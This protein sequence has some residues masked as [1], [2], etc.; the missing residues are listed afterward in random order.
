MATTTNQGQQQYTEPAHNGVTNVDWAV[1]VLQ[2]LGAPVTNNNVTTMLQWMQ[3]ENGASTWT[4]TAGANNPLNNGYGSGGG[5]GL[6]SY[7]DLATAAQDV[8][9]NLATGAHG[10]NKV[11]SDLDASAD[12][13]TTAADII[14]S[15]WAESH[16]KNGA[17]WASGV[18]AATVKLV[19]AATSAAN[20][21]TGPVATG[22][23]GG[24]GSVIQNVA[25][26]GAAAEGAASTAATDAELPFKFLGDVIGGFGIGWKA[27]LT[28]I[29][30]ILLIGV[31][32]IIAFRHQAGEAASIA[33]IG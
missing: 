14:S 9:A 12:P 17:D 19:N 22:S 1:W 30:G 13:S 16:Y 11:V 26:A 15:G 29:G 24:L 28:I 8:A 2:D 32:I 10:Y 20:G 4:G 18:S 3:S 33:A 25:G 27:V 23:N 6:G 7:P 31:G 5:S 21:A